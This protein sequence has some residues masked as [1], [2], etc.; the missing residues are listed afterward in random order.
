MTYDHV[1]KRAKQIL[2]IDKPEETNQNTKT[3]KID[4]ADIPCPF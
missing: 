3:E 4:I 2:E 1:L